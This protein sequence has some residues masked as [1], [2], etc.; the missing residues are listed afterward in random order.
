LPGTLSRIV[1]EFP[2]KFNGI[3]PAIPAG[4]LSISEFSVISW[5]ELIMDAKHIHSRAYHKAQILAK[6]EGKTP[7]QIS[8]AA[9]KAA[10]EA[11]AS[12]RSGANG[13]DI[14]WWKM[15]TSLSFYTTRFVCHALARSRLLFYTSHA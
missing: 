2:R 12:W 4:N 6:A 7:E 3:C 9:T 8:D 11:V 15:K 10:R 13:E 14:D 1:R 5:K